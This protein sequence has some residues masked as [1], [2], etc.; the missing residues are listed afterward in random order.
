MVFVVHEPAT[1]SGPSGFDANEGGGVRWPLS[2]LGAW[3]VESTPPPAETPHDTATIAL[4]NNT[5]RRRITNPQSWLNANAP[6]PRTDPKRSTLGV[7][8]R[9]QGRHHRRRTGSG[10]K[11]DMGGLVRLASHHS[12]S[13]ASG[14]SLRVQGRHSRLVRWA[15]R[16]AFTH[17]SSGRRGVSGPHAPTLANTA[18]RSREHRSS[19]TANSRLSALPA[20][21]RLSSH[22]RALQGPVSLGEARRA[23]TRRYLS[24]PRSASA[25]ANS[26]PSGPSTRTRPS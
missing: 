18:R 16:R 15:A 6:V 9:R 17:P 25:R 26:S 19:A 24:R 10:A 22:A 20:S 14:A 8:R 13:S 23:S 12:R 7:S 21:A 1:P 2:E 5:I 4:T 11:R 3:P